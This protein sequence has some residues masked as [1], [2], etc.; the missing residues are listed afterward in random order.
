MNLLRALPL[1]ESMPGPPPFL[2]MNSTPASEAPLPAVGHDRNRPITLVLGCRRN[3]RSTSTH[4]LRGLLN[5][6][7]SPAV[8]AST[9]SIPATSK[10]RRRA[11]SFAAVTGISPSTTSTLRIVATPTLDA[12]A[13]SAAVHRSMARAARSWALEIFLIGRLDLLDTISYNLHHDNEPRIG[14]EKSA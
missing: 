10:A 7:P 6:T 4:T 3:H 11:A 1:P 12:L 14:E 13:K 8:F 9:N 5:L 2:S